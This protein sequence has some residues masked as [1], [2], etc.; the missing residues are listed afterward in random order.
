MQRNRKLRNFVIYPEFQKKLILIIMNIAFIAPVII[1]AFQ[2]LAF[3][4]QIKNGQMMNL[5][6]THP[7]FI[8]YNEFQRNTLNVFM[9]SVGISF[10]L[11]LI[12]GLVISHRI[13]GPLLKLKQHFE[14][15]AQDPA[16][17]KPIKFRDNDF[18]KDLADSYNL[19]FSK[20]SKS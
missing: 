17:D 16:N 6:E 9:I 1:Y 19:K 12:I 4:Q 2:T 20:K 18:F 5:P 3:R 10:L 8:F 7:Y 15:V 13:A 14:A 11:S